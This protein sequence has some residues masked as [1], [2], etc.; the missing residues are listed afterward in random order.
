ME[1]SIIDYILYNDNTHDAVKYSEEYK[2]ISRER[3][4]IHDKLEG[5]LTEEQKQVFNEYVNSELG[6]I[7]LSNDAYFKLGLKV[8]VR[9]VS[10]CMFDEK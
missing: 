7:A 2:K 6:E 4:K 1:H 3:M 5:M 9:L 10:E 8:G